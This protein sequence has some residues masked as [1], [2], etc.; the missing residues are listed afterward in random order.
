MPPARPPPSRR[1][2]RL[3]ELESDVDWTALPVPPTELR[4]AIVLPARN[5]SALLPIALQAIAEQRHVPF[6][7]EVIVLANNCS[8]DTAARARSFAANCRACAVHVVEVA[9]PAELANVGRA[10]RALMEEATQRVQRAG[11]LRGLVISTDADTRV[12]PDWLRATAAAIDAGADAVGGRI[13]PELDDGLT[14]T[15]KRL[16]RLDDAHRIWRTR[17]ESLVD[18]DPADPWPRHHQHFGASLAVTAEAYRAV[19]GQP[20]VPYLEDE[21]LV[22]VLRLEDKR[23]RHCP[24]VR[25]H[26]SARLDGRAEVGLSWQLREWSTRAAGASGPLVADPAHEA[27]R[28]AQ[29]RLARQLWRRARLSRER[30]E[31][32][33][34]GAIEALAGELHIDRH[35]LA[36]RVSDASSFGRLWDGIEQQ[37]EP[38]A[39]HALPMDLALRQLRHLLRGQRTAPAR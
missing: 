19:G 15:A 17:L 30:A 38:I 13:V 25:V 33:A 31:P 11:S 27:R 23:I 1:W 8:D 28:W 24:Q 7:Y 18:P 36:E 20:L 39:A 35:G 12:A 26:T 3:P 32:G 22:R 9:W 21:A 34:I 16:V 37:C 29:R 6:E 5:E 4:C 2:R 14:A 10:R